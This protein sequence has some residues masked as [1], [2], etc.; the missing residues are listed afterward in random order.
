MQKINK[1]QIIC[2]STEKG[3]DAVFALIAGRSKKPNLIEIAGPSCSGKT[4]FAD[5][6]AERSL[7]EME[8]ATSQLKMDS[9]FKDIN[10]LTARDGFGRINFDWPGAYHINDFQNNVRL[11]IKGEDVLEPDYDMRKNKRRLDSGRSIKASQIIIIEG[12]YAI[13]VLRGIYENPIRV[14]I[15]VSEEIQ[16][17]RIKQRNMKEG[18]SASVIET[19][20]YDKIFPCQEKFVEPQKEMADIIIVNNFEN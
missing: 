5:R 6:A 4:Y 11:L 2:F 15:D 20:F 7:S 13:D 18:I 9:Y 3:L 19:V 10:D 1:N 16:L 14:F 17:W 12:L 8:I